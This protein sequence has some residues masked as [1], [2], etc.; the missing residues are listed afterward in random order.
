MKLI[1]DI[2]E[3]E[4]I[5]IKSFPNANTSYPWTIH[6]YDAVKN[7][8]PLENIKAEIERGS[9]LLCVGSFEKGIAKGLKVA[10]EIIDKHI[11]DTE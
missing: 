9:K 4:Y 1:I 8:I 6:L 3:N 11:G 5:G 2:P 7:G 10:L